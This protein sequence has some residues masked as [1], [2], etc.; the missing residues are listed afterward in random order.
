[1]NTREVV[2]VDYARSAF[3]KQGGV[4]KNIVNSD[5]AGYFIGKLVEKS[6]ID[7]NLIDGVMIGPGRFRHPHR[8]RR[9]ILQ[10][11][12]CQVPHPWHPLQDD[13]SCGGYAEVFSRAGDGHHHD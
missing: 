1:M 10:H 8:R 2:I 13:R 9:G 6:G 4:F 12:A 7:K 5:L 11:G 3:G